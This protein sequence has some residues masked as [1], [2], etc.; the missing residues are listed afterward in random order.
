MA[1]SLGMLARLPTS[2]LGRSFGPHD[3]FPHPPVHWRTCAHAPLTVSGKIL[4]SL[5]IT[6]ILEN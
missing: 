5:I 4:N 3:D 6:D 2:L 1:F